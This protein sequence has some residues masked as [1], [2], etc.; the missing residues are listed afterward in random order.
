MPEWK[1]W[2]RKY[3]NEWQHGWLK[4]K[5]GF[6]LGIIWICRKSILRIIILPFSIVS[7]CQTTLNIYSINE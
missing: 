1:I 6:K 7:K 4:F 3:G 5:M 2:G